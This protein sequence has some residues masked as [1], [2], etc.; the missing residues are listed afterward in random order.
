LFANADYGPDKQVNQPAFDWLTFDRL[1]ATR[2]RILQESVAFYDPAVQ[3]IVF[4]F[5]PSKS[6]NSMAIWRRK[7]KV[8]NNLRLAY[9][10][11]IG[12]AMATLRKDKDYVLH[13]DE[14]VIE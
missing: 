10:Y 4:V 8:P 3:V 2:D 5:L 7:L 13:V 11:E 1:Q 6:G 12:L 14:C 9:Q